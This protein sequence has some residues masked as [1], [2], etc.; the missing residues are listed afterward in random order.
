MTL[1]GHDG[2]G[3]PTRALLRNAA[4]KL[5]DAA[6]NSELRSLTACPVGFRFRLAR[7][8]DQSP[9]FLRHR[10]HLYAAVHN[11]ARGDART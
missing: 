9:E 6:T 8:V 10:S 11:S 4:G 7:V 1:P 2:M 3:T 5:S